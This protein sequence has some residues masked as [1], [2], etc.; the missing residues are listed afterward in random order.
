MHRTEA[1]SKRSTRLDGIALFAFGA[2][3]PLWIGHRLLFR[4]GYV[5]WGALS[6]VARAFDVFRL[7]A[8]PQISLIGFADPPLPAI[9]QLPVAGL[10]PN[11]TTSGYAA[12]VV[13]S[14]MAGLTC[15]AFNALL[16]EMGLGRRARLL[17]VAA[18]QLNPLVLYWAASGRGEVL[19]ALV[20]VLG[21]RQIVVWRRDRLHR[22]VLLAGIILS[23][24]VIVR[25]EAIFLV[26]ALSVAIGFLLR[27]EDGAGRSQIEGILIAFLLPV[28][29]VGAL[30]ILTKWAI[31]GDPFSFWADTLGAPASETGWAGLGNAVGCLFSGLRAANGGFPLYVPALVV[32]FLPLGAGDRLLRAFGAVSLSVPLC[33][34]AL[35]AGRLPGSSSC[36]EA[37]SRPSVA[38]F[39][40]LF[41]LLLTAG[42]WQSGWWRPS[43][44]RA[45]RLKVA[46]GL[47]VALVVFAG[48]GP[49]DNSS[50]ADAAHN[51]TLALRGE[52][53]SLAAYT[54]EKT[55]A[56]ETLAHV[57]N[58]PVLIVGE[59]SFAI[60]LFSGRP[61]QFV[62]TEEADGHPGRYRW[63]L[64][65]TTAASP[66]DQM[67]RPKS[68]T[69][70]DS[71]SGWELVED[72]G[73]W[74]LFRMK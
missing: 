48:G 32:L 9:L 19:L 66:R 16:A 35:A 60:R 70:R 71:A 24:A 58:D 1:G 15:L 43:A 34:A 33:F 21:L 59:L 73:Y 74:Q 2:V 5:D 47:V 46:A 29:Y 36:Q 40:L 38:L 11:L 55:V 41:G 62:A 26:L 17:F 23:L 50:V 68:A 67:S 14:L 63:F 13:M 72:W 65:E 6:D 39:G 27:T 56:A 7:N 20:T 30:W 57:G 25:Y 37:L 3:V 8:R 69:R 54:V 12:C 64:Q 61:R 45:D 18:W 31:V 4:C 49:E 28:V 52:A 42:I 44:R 53:G 22:D 10:F 51:V